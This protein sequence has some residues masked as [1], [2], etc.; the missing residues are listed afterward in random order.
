MIR[1]SVSAY[2][3]HASSFAITAAAELAFVIGDFRPS[4]S[5]SWQPKV[6]G[7]VRILWFG[8]MAG[9]IVFSMKSFITVISLTAGSVEF[10]GQRPDALQ[11][12]ALAESNG[13]APESCW[14]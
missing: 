6:P 1:G 3:I 9:I 11:Q 14:G 8:C 10:C 5:T 12:G 4:A 2:F 7:T 13:A